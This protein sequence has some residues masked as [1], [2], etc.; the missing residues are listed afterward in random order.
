MSGLLC[1]TLSLHVYMSLSVINF[2][3]RL[4]VRLFLSLSLYIVQYT[5]M[6]SVA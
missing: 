3:F 4:F 5:M 1:Y 2:N 6:N